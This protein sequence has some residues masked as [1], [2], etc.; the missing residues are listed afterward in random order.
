MKRTDT[1]PT[2]ILHLYTDAVE[3]FSFRS[4]CPTAASGR[5]VFLRQRLHLYRH[6]H[7]V[8]RNFIFVLRILETAFPR[9]FVTM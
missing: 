3:S 5:N 9:V 2:H 4:S 7:T 6:T 1:R 8:F